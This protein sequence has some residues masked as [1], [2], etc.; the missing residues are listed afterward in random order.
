MTNVTSLIIHP[1]YV[2]NRGIDCANALLIAFDVLDQARYAE[3]HQAAD[4][5]DL[6]WLLGW[7][8]EEDLVEDQCYGRGWRPEP[9]R[10]YRRW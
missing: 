8:K 6:G 9:K 3:E 7:D 5:E 2:P 1:A 10:N 4:Q